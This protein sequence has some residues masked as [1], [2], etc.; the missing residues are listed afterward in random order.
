MTCEAPVEEST[1][2]LVGVPF[3]LAAF[4]ILSL[5]F[6]ILIVVCLGVDL[7][8]LILLWLSV[9]PGPERLFF[10]TPRFGKF[11]ALLLQIISLTLLSLSSFW[12]VYDVN[13]HMLD[14]V[15]EVS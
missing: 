3:S 11:S 2:S 10:F 6:V 14:V 7:F 1:D 5:I 13:V 9:L 15:P 8:G 12:D 4:K